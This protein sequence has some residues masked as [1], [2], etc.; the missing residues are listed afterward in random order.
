MADFCFA[1]DANY[2]GTGAKPIPNFLYTPCHCPVG[3]HCHDNTED[4][5]PKRLKRFK[6]TRRI[7][8]LARPRRVRQKFRQRPVLARRQETE[9][10]RSYQKPYASRRIQQLALPRVRSLLVVRQ[11]YRH[12]LSKVQAQQLNKW[13]KKSVLT[14]Y[15]QLASVELPE[16]P[17]TKIMTTEDWQRHQQWLERNARHRQPPAIPKPP[18]N[19]KPLA[20][21]RDRI[22]SLSTPKYSRKKVTGKEPQIPAVK[23]A[24]LKTTPSEHVVKLAQPIARRR[25]AKGVVTEDTSI[26]ENVLKAQASV[27]IL[28]LAS[29]KRY[30]KVNNEYRDTPF[31]VE[32]NALKAKPSER[33][34]ELAKPK[35]LSKK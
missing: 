35:K 31:T 21:L 9:I 8:W 33:V 17:A 24:A 34:L 22:G 25:R 11:H 3:D 18:I 4:V 32:P 29:P 23:P 30:T 14:I 28:E 7:R 6:T 1:V 5:V 10:I 2:T 12:L 15:S 13:I 16:Q 20:E 27:R 19:R 26:P